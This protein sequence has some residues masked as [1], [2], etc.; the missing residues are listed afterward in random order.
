MREAAL[1]V[2]RTLG[3]VAEEIGMGVTPRFLDTMAEEYIRSQK[4]NLQEAESGHGIRGVSPEEIRR[5]E[6]L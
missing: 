2:S 3:K 4:A 1:V 5:S 6:A